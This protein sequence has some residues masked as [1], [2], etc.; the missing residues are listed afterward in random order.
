MTLVWIDWLIIGLFAIV[1]LGI[2][3]YFRGQAGKDLSSFFLGGR[4]LPWWIVGTS[5][6]ATT[7]AAD[8]PLAVTE[9]V[10]KDGI[11]GNWIWWNMLAGGMLTTFF[12]ARYWRRAGV[13]TDVELINIRYSGPEAGILRVFRSV[14][15][16]V[17]MNVIIMAWVNTALKDLL[18]VFFEMEPMQAYGVVIIAMFLVAAYTSLS[19]ILGVAYTD[20]LQF[21]LAMT[22][23]IIL[24][25]L[26]VNSDKVGGMTA[27]QSKLPEG[28][29]NFFPQIGGESAGSTL[30]IGLG[31]FLA[32]IGMQWW[33]SWYPG[34][35]PGGGGYIVQRV[36]SAKDERH[37]VYSTLFFQIA[38]YCLRPWPWIIVALCAVVLYP[39]LADPK[40]GYVEAMKEFLPTGLKGMMLAAFFAA[41]M[42]TISTHLNWGASYLVND[43]Y[44][45]MKPDASQRQYVAASRLVT[46]GL[47]VIALVSSL[48]V[49]SI[50]DA[51]AFIIEC[52]AGLGLV[53][54]L[55]WYWWRIN[56]WSEISA[57]IAPFIFYGIA[58]FI[59]KL[60]FP[61]S[62]FLTLGGTTITWLVVTFLTP[63]SEETVLQQFY[64]KV[65]PDGAWGPFNG[66]AGAG[67]GRLARLAII[68]LAAISFA[69]STL[70][71]IGQV[72]FGNYGDAAISGA[73]A[74]VSLALVLIFMRKARL[75]EQQG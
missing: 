19:G 41:Y 54:I 44:K 8:T 24:A 43:V 51:W 21:V 31:T 17:F 9:I 63:P 29:L 58:H 5:M 73:I 50:K 61:W 10:A 38:H 28:S 72:L 2:G 60:A 27:L 36:M 48:F 4:N 33:A 1:T 70:F 22:G 64:D 59:L 53:F 14:Y 69:Y 35:E 52:G 47:T 55:R 62:F 37:A 30:A 18:I 71:L 40:H 68:W 46:V 57:T 45:D 74:L 66:G 34:A 20:V 32:Y 65:R 12:F 42:S 15:F 7:F 16:G 13:L 75:F 49:T 26:V 6:V 11:S 56:A 25:V 39:D 67:A 3:F 23:S